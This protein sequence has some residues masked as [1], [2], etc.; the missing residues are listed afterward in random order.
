[1]QKGYPGNPILAHPMRY[2]AID[3][4]SVPSLVQLTDVRRDML[5]Q[6]TYPY[7]GLPYY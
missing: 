6:N 3:M 5:L 1:M 4:A 7:P 2:G